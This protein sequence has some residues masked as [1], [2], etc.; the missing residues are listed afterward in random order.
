MELLY[1]YAFE[2]QESR[3]VLALNVIFSAPSFFCLSFSFLQLGQ[4]PEL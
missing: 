3:Y 2:R 4:T 1:L